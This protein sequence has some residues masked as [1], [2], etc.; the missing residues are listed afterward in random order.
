MLRVMSGNVFEQ[1]LESRLP[2]LR[3]QHF[4]GALGVVL[5]ASVF[6]LSAHANLPLPSWL[7]Y[8]SAAGLALLAWSDY[9]TLG[10]PDQA[11]RMGEAVL[12][13]LARACAPTA[14]PPA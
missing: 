10:H 7:K 13:A 11:R 4:F 5:L 14:K 2:R 8:G 1:E 3:R 6:A 9:K 12:D